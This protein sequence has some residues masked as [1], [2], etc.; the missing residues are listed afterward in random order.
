MNASGQTSAGLDWRG[1]DRTAV[2]AAARQAQPENAPIVLSLHEVSAAYG[3]R[4]VLR[5]VTCSIP[6]GEITA[7]LG[8][9]GCGKSTLLRVPIEPWN[10]SRRGAYFPVPWRSAVKISTTAAFTPEPSASASG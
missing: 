4:V 1:S 3:E 2:V 8:P 7:I 9:S 10:L 5:N 6:H